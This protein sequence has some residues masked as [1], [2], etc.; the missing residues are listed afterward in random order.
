MKT[1]LLFFIGIISS[2]T[3]AQDGTL[4][5]SFGNNGFA[6]TD[7]FGRS[8]RGTSI[9]VQDN[10][11]IIIY[12]FASH[13]GGGFSYA[14]AGHLPDGSL[15]P[16]FG[17]GG[18]VTTQIGDF[19][20][21][22]FN[23]LHIQPDQ[24]II[25]ST[26]FFENG[27]VGFLLV[28]YLPNGTL[29]TSFGTDGIVKTSYAENYLSGTVLLPDGKIL[30][31]G[32]STNGGDNSILLVKYLP[33]GSLDTSFGT[34]G[35]LFHF[36]NNESF[37]VFG[38]KVQS[39]GKILV[40]YKTEE[41]FV[42]KFQIAR[43]LPNGVLDTDFG[44]VGIVEIE[45]STEVFHSSITIQDDGKILM[46]LRTQ[47]GTSIKRFLPSGEIDTSF[48]N[49]GTTII[50]GD[51]FTALKILVQPDD[52]IIVF[53]ITFGFEP[54][55]NRT[56]RFNS[57]GILDTTFGA[58]GYTALGF[59]GADIAFQ[60]D[61]K[62]VI[63]GNT[64]FYSGSESFVVARLNNGSLSVSEFE[65]DSFKIYPNPSNGIFTIERELFSENTPFQ[66]TDSTGKII[67]LGELTEKQTQLNLS[68]AQSGVYFLKTS[69]SVFRLLKN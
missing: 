58:N 31:G 54:D 49:N 43:F 18:L 11:R 36:I 20:E 55:F 19:Y 59:E 1:L 22:Y 6:I 40:P 21:E 10:G 2:L 12:G 51:M 4:D 29:D 8:D 35:S 42:K 38:I 32:S 64:F 48:G 47:P 28:R 37:K 44:V 61:G 68:S 52:A 27:E 9:A 62:L 30:A 25:T 45:S 13:S 24:K 16:T 63:G 60:Q 50:D 3:Y 34:N 15:D 67:V 66:I 57:E 17:I 26:T 69:N 23:S 7:F 46:S 39:D 33:D 65:N 14:L 5:T 53:G 56:Y 41:N